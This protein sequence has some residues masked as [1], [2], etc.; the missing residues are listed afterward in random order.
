MPAQRSSLVYDREIKIG[1]DVTVTFSDTSTLTGVLRFYYPNDQIWVIQ[2][3]TNTHYVKDFWR[4]S[5]IVP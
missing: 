3:G 4:I 5:K 1:E 2:E